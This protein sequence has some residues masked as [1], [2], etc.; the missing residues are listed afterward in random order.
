MALTVIFP[1]G[2]WPLS[3]EVIL[4]THPQVALQETNGLQ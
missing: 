3:R 2:E 1:L 4:T